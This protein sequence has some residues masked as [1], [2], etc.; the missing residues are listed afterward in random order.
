[1]EKELPPHIRTF[2][3]TDTLGYLIDRPSPAPL[4]LF[5]GLERGTASVGSPPSAR[6]V[7]NWISRWMSSV[8]RQAARLAIIRLVSLIASWPP[9]WAMRASS[10]SRR[11]LAQVDLPSTPGNRSWP[12]VRR[13]RPFLG[14]SAVEL[15]LDISGL[16][17]GLF[18]TASKRGSKVLVAIYDIDPAHLEA[19]GRG[20]SEL[21][22]KSR[23]E[24]DINRR[25]E[26][27][28]VTE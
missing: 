18:R 24:D 11:S 25:V 14:L 5:H 3:H 28:N 21:K 9:Q 20:K 15:A 10:V 27:R 8:S 22:D 6:M 13:D 4:S 16:S 1:V 7:A 23:P 26:I 19:I 17:P 2:G 12:L